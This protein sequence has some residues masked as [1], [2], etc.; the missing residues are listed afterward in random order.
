LENI[1]VKLVYYS[2][3]VFVFA[4]LFTTILGIINL[5]KLGIYKIFILLTSGAIIQTIYSSLFNDINN[6]EENLNLVDLYVNYYLVFELIILSYYF[7]K[8]IIGKSQKIITT[9]LNGSLILYLL[10]ISIVKPQLISYY[11]SEIAAI[12]AITI[13]INCI[14]LFVQILNDEINSSLLNSPDF[15]ITSGIFFLF[16]FTCPYY[17][18]YTKIEFNFSILKS[19]FSMVNYIG[20]VFFHLSIIK[21]FK[22]KIRLSRL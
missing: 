20:Y 8:K 12:E 4:A 21:A 1:L 3:G 17:V 13:L 2:N 15:I 22:C 18:L 14:F 16:S 7:Y 9:I 19:C 5:K 6:I 11:Y 10:P